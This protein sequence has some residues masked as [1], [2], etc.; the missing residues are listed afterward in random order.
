MLRCAALVVELRVGGVRFRW[1]TNV[2]ELLVLLG[3]CV[4]VSKS[5]VQSGVEKEKDR[6]CVG[7]IGS[8]VW[9]RVQ[10]KIVWVGVKESR[11][12]VMLREGWV[13]VRVREKGVWTTVGEIEVCA[14]VREI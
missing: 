13:C 1:W 11:V 10:E 7:K 4:I 5:E 12:W 8:R 6:V 2:G 3:L 9:S 14:A